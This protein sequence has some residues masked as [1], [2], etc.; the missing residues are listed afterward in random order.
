MSIDRGHVLSEMRG[1]GAQID[2]C[3]REEGD[4]EGSNNDGTEEEK[5][6]W[7]ERC[8]PTEN[9]GCGCRRRDKTTKIDSY[10]F[11][12]ASKAEGVITV[13]SD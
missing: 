4:C 11:R 2:D 8:I 5:G 1:R 9:E 6:E 7:G 13:K 12:V 10:T 3:W